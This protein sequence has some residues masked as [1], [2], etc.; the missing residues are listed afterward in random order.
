MS[1]TAANSVISKLISFAAIAVLGWYLDDHD[2]GLYAM[3]FSIAAFLQIFRDG[4][5]VQLLIQRGEKEYAH[6]LGPVFWMAFAFNTATALALCA[7]APVAASLKSEPMLAPLIW[8]LALTMPLSTPGI[9]FISRLQMRLRFGYLNAVSLG[10]SLIR[11]GGTIGLA[12]SGFGPMSFVLPMPVIALY[13]GV[14]YF[15]AVREKPWTRSPRLSMWR[16]LFSHSKWLIFFA[17]SIATLNQGGYLVIGAIV[18]LERVGVFAFAFQLI[19][20]V[21]ALLGTLGTVLFPALARLNDDPKRQEHATMRTI[22]VLM[23][24]ACPAALGLAAVVD[25]LEQL[26]W[27]GKWH[28]AVWP[29]QALALFYAARI[30]ITIPNAALQARGKFRVNATLTLLAGLGTMTAAGIGAAWG[31]ASSNPEQLTP[32]RIAECMGVA[33]GVFCTGFS[34][35]GLSKIQLSWRRVLGAVAPSWVFAVAAAG[36]V[37]VLDHFTSAG[38]GGVAQSL[39]DRLKAMSVPLADKD[40]APT[41]IDGLLRLVMAFGVYCAS[42]GVLF[43][44]FAPSRLVEAMA[45]VPGP[46]RRV[47]M[48]VAMLRHAS[49][50]ER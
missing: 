40:W 1:F 35:W 30:L 6:L 2:F 39:A 19:S 10:S 8:V 45:V 23:F 42:Y 12:V 33:I 25:P 46:L 20:Q 3:A 14:A 18:D 44:V 37:I 15:L 48:R 26:L 4:G 13:E 41:A 34:L 7:I 17:L 47:A 21:D 11:Y 5:V 27:H 28:A 36:I 43:R 16:E 22:R 31:A 32:N 9:I 50:T 49:P 29:V 38:V 24:L